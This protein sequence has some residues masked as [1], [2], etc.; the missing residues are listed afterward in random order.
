[1]KGDL[2]TA[3]RLVKSSVDPNVADENGQVPLH[4]LEDV[5]LP[6]ELARFQWYDLFSGSAE[7]LA[8]QLARITLNPTCPPR[9]SRRPRP[10]DQCRSESLES[11]EE[12]KLK[13]RHLKC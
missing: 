5:D 12:Q 7:G 6:D 10:R 13:R 2:A 9:P 3:E 8:A 4:F 11:S 1:M